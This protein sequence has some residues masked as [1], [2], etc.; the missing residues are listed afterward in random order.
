MASRANFTNMSF[1]PR[2]MPSAPG[3]LPALLRIKPGTDRIALVRAA[4]LAL[5]VPEQKESR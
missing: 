1:P 2:P 3:D 5:D 4:L